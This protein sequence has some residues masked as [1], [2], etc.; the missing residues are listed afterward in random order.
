MGIEKLKTLKV[1]GKT[2]VS[3][4][5][6]EEL[7]A[8]YAAAVKATVDY[9]NDIAKLKRQFE[10]LAAKKDAADVRGVLLVG[11]DEPKQLEILLGAFKAA[12]KKTAPCSPGGDVQ[13]G[14]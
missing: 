6:H 10:E 7:K 11:L 12:T 5:E 3:A 8:K 14:A 4:K 2:S 9:D 1:K 13:R